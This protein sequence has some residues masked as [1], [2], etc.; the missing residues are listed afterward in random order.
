[1]KM[2]GEATEW[3]Q[4]S[5]E[6]LSTEQEAALVTEILGSGVEQLHALQQ[7]VGTP[8]CR[9]LVRCA[10]LDHLVELAESNHRQED[11]RSFLEWLVMTRFEPNEDVRIVGYQWLADL[12]AGRG[13]RDP[14]L[15][16]K[17]REELKRRLE[18][19]PSPRV[20]WLAAIG[21]L[22]K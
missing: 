8:E 15:Q 5:R 2:S 1:M 11:A 19:D 7:V 18:Q 4:R 10:A 17:Q 13:L 21:T 16:S 3:M 9:A 14:V 20:R 12:S 6:P 22:M